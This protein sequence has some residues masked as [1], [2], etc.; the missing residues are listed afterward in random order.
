MPLWDTQPSCVPST[1]RESL[2]ESDPLSPLCPGD[3]TGPGIPGGFT[4]LEVGA[5][6]TW[7]TFMGL[8]R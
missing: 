7:A 4:F 8:E 5:E 3:A 6:G 2:S 1:G